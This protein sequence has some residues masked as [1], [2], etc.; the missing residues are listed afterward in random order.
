M[1]FVDC[2]VSHLTGGGQQPNEDSSEKAAVKLAG[3]LRWKRK[4]EEDDSTDVTNADDGCADYPKSTDKNK[5]LRNVMNT[6]KTKGKAPSEFVLEL[7]EQAVEQHLALP[8]VINV[9]RNKQYRASF[10]HKTDKEIITSH[11]QGN[12]TVVGDVHGQYH[13]FAQIF[14]NEWLAGGL[15]STDNQFIFNGDIVDRGPMSVEI[16]IVLLLAKV[17]CADSVHI[18]RGNHEI[19]AMNADHGFSKEVT[20]KY[21]WRMLKKFQTLFRALPFAAV[22]EDAVFVTHGGL[23]PR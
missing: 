22:I 4:R 20:E 15:P 5:M 11:Y 7:L 9:S 18:V 14:E 1:E 10:D 2:I 23:G 13:D 6:F 8:N 3:L 12:V 19:A 17:L 16:V 21:D